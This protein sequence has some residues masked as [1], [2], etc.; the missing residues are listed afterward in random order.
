MQ[1][2]STA[3]TTWDWIL[4]IDWGRAERPAREDGVNS[5]LE[6]LTTLE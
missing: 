6:F 2:S 5:E 4:S 1:A 3:P